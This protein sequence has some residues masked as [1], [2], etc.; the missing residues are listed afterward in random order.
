MCKISI[1]KLWREVMNNLISILSDKIRIFIYLIISFLLRLYLLIF[2]NN[3]GSDGVWYVTLGK[4]LIRGKGYIN[5]LG[6]IDLQYP[7]FY[8][9]IIGLTSIF[10]KD[11]ELAARLISLIFG[12]LLILPIFFLGK[13]F[14]EKKTGY[15]ATILIIF[16]P[17]LC[18]YSVFVL[19]ESIY[20]FLFILSILLGWYCIVTEKIRYH[21]LVGLLFGICTLT[22]PEGVIFFLIFLVTFLFFKYKKIYSKKMLS[23]T[24]LMV[25]IFFLIISPYVVFI[26]SKTGEWTL[27]KKSSMVSYIS[28]TMRNDKYGYEKSHFAIAENGVDLNLFNENVSFFCCFESG[29]KRIFKFYFSNIYTMYREYIPELIPLVL[30]IPLGIGLLQVYW[31]RGNLK[32]EFYLFSFM[33]PPMLVYPF[34]LIHSRRFVPFIPIIILLIARGIVFIQ[35]RAKSLKRCNSY[36]NSSYVEKLIAKGIIAFFVLVILPHAIAKKNIDDP[37]YK[38]LGTLLKNHVHKQSAL[39]ARQP[40]ISFYSDMRFVHFPYDKDYGKVFKYAEY[41]GVN[42]LVIDYNILAFRD[43]LSYLRDWYNERNLPS[44]LKL[45]SKYGDTP[46][47]KILIYEFFPHR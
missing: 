47:K 22:R 20:T 35:D 8:P 26:H 11:I 24:F 36:K 6:E 10:I 43:H 30:F 25:L 9:I 31:D 32:K 28:K 34:F 12:T 38:K 2:Q 13:N 40:Y 37:N 41:H 46:T 18:Q 3:I 1:S 4:N 27:G 14:Y 44:E 19:T 45:I 29:Y 21:I 39:M 15:V 42:Y 16:Y 5:Q 33:I 23:G 7:P 17:V